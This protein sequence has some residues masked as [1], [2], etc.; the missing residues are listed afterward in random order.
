MTAWIEVLTAL[1]TGPDVPIRGSIRE[2]RPDGSAKKEGFASFTTST[3]MLVLTG[4]GC[5]VWRSGDRLRVER[6][7]RPIFATDGTRAWD[8]TAD[9]ERPRTGPPTASF[10]WAGTSSY[11]VDAAPPSGRAMTSP[12]PPAGRRDGLRRPTLLDSRAR[13][14]RT[15]LIRS[16][17][18]WIS[19]PVRCSATGPSGWARGRSSSSS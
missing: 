11:Y 14:P 18:G 19:S 9:S 2:V 17:S 10:I 1:T 5:R 15:S 13:P 12:S 3:P 7:G 4:D 8:F 6:D 16:G